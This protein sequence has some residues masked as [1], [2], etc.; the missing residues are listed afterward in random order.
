MREKY[1][2]GA[3]DDGQVGNRRS[4]FYHTFRQLSEPFRIFRFS[5]FESM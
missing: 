1:S 2:Y 4:A 3:V 5:I